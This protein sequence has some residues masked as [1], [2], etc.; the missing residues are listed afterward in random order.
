ME[1]FYLD[2]DNFVDEWDQMNYD[3]D[4]DREFEITPDGEWSSA[5]DY[6]DHYDED[7]REVDEDQSW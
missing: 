6:D 1:N 4:E 2:V 3:P 7:E 5:N